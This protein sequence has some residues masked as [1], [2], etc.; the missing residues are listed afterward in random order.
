MEDQPV[1][2]PEDVHRKFGKDLFNGTWTL[3]EKPDRS[4]D[5][6]ALMIHMAHASN[7]HWLQVGKPENFAR[8]HWLCSRV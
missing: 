5:E 7:Y 2:S 4:P 6:D 8:G 1:P 3:M